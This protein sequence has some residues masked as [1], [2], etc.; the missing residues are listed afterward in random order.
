[1]LISY[2]WEVLTFGAVVY[3]CACRS[4]VFSYRDYQRKD[5][6]LA[7][8]A[9]P[10]RPER[11][12]RCRPIRP[13]RPRWR[14]R[15]SRASELIAGIFLMLRATS[16]IKR[17]PPS[18]RLVADTVILDYAQRNAAK[19][20]V[21]GAKGT[22]STSTCTCRYG[23]APTTCC[24]LDDG[25]LVEVVAAPEPLIEAR[26]SDLAGCRGCLHLG[27]RHIPVQVSSIAVRRAARRGGP[28]IADVARR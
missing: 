10:P 19:V 7:A 27:D 6:E 13:A 21:T 3:S 12:G 15:P 4:A 18:R 5:A 25:T 14:W 22:S 20:T 26:A 28:D 24:L 11:Y 9:P 17:R 8:A 1:V 16:V 23:C 2:P